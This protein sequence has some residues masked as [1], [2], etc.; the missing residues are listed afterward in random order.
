MLR[1]DI[2]APGRGVE[3]LVLDADGD[4]RA[5]D[6]AAQ[7]ALGERDPWVSVPC[8]D[9]GRV[10]DRLAEHGFRSPLQPEWMM[11]IPLDEQLRVPLADGLSHSLEASSGGRVLRL[12]VLDAHGALASSGQLGMVDGCAVPDKIEVQ[13]TH[14]RRGLG[15]AMMTALVDAARDAGARRGLLMASTEG[16]ALYSS[17]GWTT[18]GP[19]VVGRLWA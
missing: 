11:S 16:R 18:H 5:I 6:R 13:P 7:D 9:A 15:G 3:R 8:S 17:L 14:R 4:P 12:R 19:V 1:V 10:A 2:G